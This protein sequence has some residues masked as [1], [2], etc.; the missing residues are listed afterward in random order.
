[1][2][3]TTQ[4]F[5]KRIWGLNFQEIYDPEYP[6]WRAYIQNPFYD[7]NKGRWV[8]G[9]NEKFLKTAI[10]QGI[11]EIKIMAGTVEVPIRTPNEKELRKKDKLEEFELRKSMFEKGKPMKIYHFEI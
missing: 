6:V 3:Q 7:K 10:S 4:E 2:T 1:M 9:L 11:K 5:N 8:I